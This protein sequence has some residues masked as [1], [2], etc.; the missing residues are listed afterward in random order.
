MKLK[1]NEAQQNKSFQVDTLKNCQKVLIFI[2]Q[3]ITIRKL[4]M[5]HLKQKVKFQEMLLVVE[6]EKGSMK[7]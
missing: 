5:R 1:N 6:S 7:K 3:S 2:T 4:D